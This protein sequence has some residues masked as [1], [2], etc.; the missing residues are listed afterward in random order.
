MKNILSLISKLKLTKMDQNDLKKRLFGNDMSDPK[1]AVIEGENYYFN[2]FLNVRIMKK[3][4]MFKRD[5]SNQWSELYDTD[6]ET[7]Y[8]DN[9]L[10]KYFE[11]KI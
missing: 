3:I 10:V 2:K 1:V 9:S 8:L 11:G 5:L 6:N 7:N 4:L